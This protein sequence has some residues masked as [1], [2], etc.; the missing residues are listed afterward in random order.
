MGLTMWVSRSS[1]RARLFLPVLLWPGLARGI[2]AVL[3]SVPLSV[4]AYA[5]TDPRNAPSPVAPG[6]LSKP[7]FDTMTPSYD[8]VPSPDKAASTVVA[9]V[10]G[11]PITMGDVGDAIRALPP[12]LSQ[13]P[14]DS[15][16]PGI[17]DQLIKTQALVVR[18]QQQG[19]D[20]EPAV[21]R[22]VKE[23]ADL[24]LAE[25]YVQREVSQ[26]ITEQALLERY[27][28]DIAGH[29]GPD[30]V[31][32]RVILTDTEK[33]AADAIA[34]I[35]GGADFATVARRVSRDTT[36][37]AGGDLGFHDRAGMNPEVGAVAFMLPVGQM[38]P[39]PVRAA[40]GWFVIKV[41]ERRQQP[42][43]GF[44]EVREQLRQTLMR[45]AAVPFAEAAMKDLKIRKYSIAG[46]ETDGGKSPDDPSGRPSGKPSGKPDSP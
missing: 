2:G 4:P 27:N 31:R 15:L 36:A 20:E 18:A 11:R 26:T 6:D 42:T 40:A 5:Q 39:N 9:E 10:E 1:F 19:V 32:A 46:G 28:R 35:R 25:E 24:R 44:A 8:S 43:P 12:S 34:E 22:K 38:T 7:V 30:E 3:L 13:L 45:E 16:Y 41:E 14:L 29:P 21:R 23:A 17:L 37:P 33:A